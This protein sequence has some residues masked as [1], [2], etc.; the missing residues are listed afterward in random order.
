MDQP[1]PCSIDNETL[2]I[3]IWS[4]KSIREKVEASFQAIINECRIHI[5]D[6]LL[7]RRFLKIRRFFPLHVAIEREKREAARI[8]IEMGYD[9]NTQTRTHGSALHLAIKYRQYKEARWLMSMGADIKRRNSQNENALSLAARHGD[10]SFIR[11]FW[12]FIDGKVKRGEINARYGEYGTTIAGLLAQ[13]CKIKSG[14]TFCKILVMG[15]NINKP[16]TLKARAQS[17]LFLHEIANIGDNPLTTQLIRTVLS[18]ANVE[19]LYGLFNP[20]LRD[21]YGLTLLHYLT[22]RNAVKA[23]KILLEVDGIDINIISDNNK[24]PLNCA[25]ERGYHCIAKALINYGCRL[26]IKSLWY[27]VVPFDHAVEN[28]CFKVANMIL[29]IGFEVETSSSYDKIKKGEINGIKYK[30]YSRNPPSLSNLA[31]NTIRKQTILASGNLTTKKLSKTGLPTSLIKRTINPLNY[32]FSDGV[33]L[34]NGQRD[35]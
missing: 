7:D 16:V 12:R 11:F 10:D 34:R 9:I 19:R 4:Q 31:I 25:I 33:L 30:E 24:T 13:N 26:D 21:Q 32:P 2:S 27:E 20:N 28:A 5:R 17:N 3:G 14:R 6:I 15:A 1:C 8:M 23:V 29:Q 35:K 22:K 18:C